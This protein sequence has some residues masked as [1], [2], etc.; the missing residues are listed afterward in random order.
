V[1]EWPAIGVA[2]LV[3]PLVPDVAM[4]LILT[5]EA[6]KEWMA[7]LLMPLSCYQLS[8]LL[9]V[10]LGLPIFLV[11]RQLHWLRW[12]VALLVGYAFGFLLGRALSTQQQP[13]RT[14]PPTRHS[15]GSGPDRT[16]GT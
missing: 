2:V 1:K 13:R 16:D 4:G 5:V 7:G 9:T 15:R 14:E 10:I 3:T 12:W 11:L 6:P 8:L